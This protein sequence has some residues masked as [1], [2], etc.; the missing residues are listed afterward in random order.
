MKAMPDIFKYLD[1]RRYLKDFY[2]AKKRQKGSAFSFRSFA[3]DAGF[4]SPNFLKLVMEGKRNLGVRGITQFA[5]G[6][7]LNKQEAIYFK[8]LVHFK[9][10]ETDAERNKWYR[11]L[12]TSKRYREI[13]EIERDQFDYYSNWY[14]VAIRELVLLDDFKEKAEWIAK[15]LAPPIT[16]K[17]AK[18]SLELLQRLGFLK[19]DSKGRLIQAEQNISTAREVQSLAIANFHRQMIAQGSDSIEKTPPDKRDISSLT[20]AIPEGKF[21]EAKKRIQEFRRELNVLLSDDKE[22]DSVYQVNFQI[23]NLTEVPWPKH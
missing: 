22:S 14:N 16:A 3:R 13:K 6:L 5:K 20:L 23:F 9:Q 18:D 21:Q 4:S 1:Y 11:R 15:K 2:Q 12:A 7:R 17:Q 8:S 10:V 19:R